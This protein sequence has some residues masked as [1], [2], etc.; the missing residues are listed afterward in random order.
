MSIKPQYS[1]EFR[2]IWLHDPELRDWL[3]VIESTTGPVAKCKFCGVILRS[4]YGDLKSHGM[5]K[6][7]Q[8]NKKVNKLFNTYCKFDISG[9]ANWSAKR[10]LLAGTLDQRFEEN[11]WQWLHVYVRR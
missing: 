4:H 9:L 7:H 11:R 1:Q 3:Q 8:Q 5:S 6:K 10:G 2:D